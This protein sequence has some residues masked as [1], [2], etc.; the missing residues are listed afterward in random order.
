MTQVQFSQH[1]SLQMLQYF[2]V[3]NAI[4]HWNCEECT[5]IEVDQI[6]KVNVDYWFYDAISAELAFITLFL[7]SLMSWASLSAMRGRMDYQWSDWKLYESI[8]K[9]DTDV[10]LLAFE[11]KADT[12]R[13]QLIFHLI[14]DGLHKLGSVEC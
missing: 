4:S 8:E 3:S 2:K 6:G 13:K 10:P 1:F 9:V 7:L 14:S 5:Q 12:G 11:D